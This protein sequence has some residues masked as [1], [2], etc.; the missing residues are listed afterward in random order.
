MKK[1]KLLAWIVLMPLISAAQLQIT[2]LVKDAQTLEPLAGA[3]ILLDGTFL[4]TVTDKNG[5]FRFSE[6]K[7]DN[8]FMAVSYVGYENYSTNVQPAKDHP[9]EILMQRKIILEDEVVISS[10]RMT[11]AMPA[12]YSDISK[13]ELRRSNL[14]KDM[15]MLLQTSPGVVVTSDAG[16][17][18]GYTGIRIRG[19]D[20]TRI[21]VTVNGIPLNDPESH[22]VFWVNLPDLASSVESIQ[23]QRGVGTSANGA[24]AFGASI[25]IQT[26]GLRSDPYAELSSSAGSFNTFKNNVMLGTGLID[27]KFT[28]DARLSK[29]TSD[30]YVDR[31]F[32][33]LKSFFVSGGY[34]SD[35]S[36]FR[37]KVFSG[38]EQTYQA[39]NGVPL[40]SLATNRTY[41]PSGEYEDEEGNLRY[42][43]NETDNYRQDHYQLFFSRQ[44][45][46]QL[47]LNLAAFYV[48]G[49]GYYE[50]FKQN[51]RFSKYGLPHVIVGGDTI[52]KT[53]LVRRK[54][55]DN[56]FTG[57]NLSLNYTPSGQTQ[58]F[59]GGGLNHYRGAHYGTVHWADFSAGAL[60]GRRYYENDGLKIQYDV[61]VKVIHRFFDRFNAYADVQLRGVNY[62]IEGI[63]DDLRDISQQHDFLF[64]NPKI[65]L[66]YDITQ[67]HQVYFSFA[68]ANREPTRSDYRDA[69]ESHNPLPEKLLN[70]EL[71]HLINYDRFRINTNFY[72]MDY[73]D[74]LVLTGKINNVGSPIFTNVPS[75][76][77][78]GVELDAAWKVS[79][80]LR[81]SGN[82]TISRNKIKAFTEFV[83][84]WD[85]PYEQISNELGETDISFSPSVIAN[86]IFHFTP[87]EKL[88]L[89]LVSRYVGKQF[90]DNT[91]GN[92]RALDPW[93]VNDVRIN[94]TL[95]T[96]FIREIEVHLLINNIFNTEYES[97]AWVYRYILNGEYEQMAGYFPQAGINVLGGVTLKF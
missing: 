50:N 33:D 46:R 30:G 51:Q 43:D 95:S 21:N 52:T 65:G 25:N 83:D 16:A 13:E 90:F 38:K 85:P 91:S 42:Y 67:R 57:G 7:A 15:P 74:Q 37:V 93:F 82:V 24:A 61:F 79:N 39:W 68:G 11:K 89:S 73:K 62:E 4:K 56:H 87:V 66:V 26:Q 64:F 8:Y 20:I 92:D 71:G 3:H 69:D 72:Y 49:F 54:Y 18:I 22:G 55:L 97:N 40:D 17:G 80:M 6:L 32:S 28:I 77:R 60:P 76:Y 53:D 35:K 34:Y 19:T 29:I 96:D 70:Y 63:H 81:W 41:N 78:V 1:L 27:G 75:S 23:I 2:G 86:S 5:E 88:N 12:T 36:I 45:N 58:V 31:A 10:T 59:F 47:I 94:Y 9:I 84:S 44:L 14:G 48:R